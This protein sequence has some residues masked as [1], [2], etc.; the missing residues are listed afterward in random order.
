MSLSSSLPLQ[1]LADIR[2]NEEHAK[3]H[4]E[5]SPVTTLA[6]IV[7]DVSEHEVGPHCSKSHI[8]HHTMPAGMLF[9]WYIA[10]FTLSMICE[11]KWGEAALLPNGQ[12]PGAPLAGLPYG[13][14]PQPHGACLS[15][16]KVGRAVPFCSMLHKCCLAGLPSR[17]CSV[18]TSCLTCQS[19]G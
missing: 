18:T 16:H 8:A 12:C 3:E 19:K 7:P 2:P 13:A 14:L 17:S 1:M 15:Q 9:R 5:R 6:H 10:S 11:S 4:I